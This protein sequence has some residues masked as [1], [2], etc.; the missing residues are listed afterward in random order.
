MIVSEYEPIDLNLR[1]SRLDMKTPFI[2]TITSVERYINMFSYFK[3]VQV[4]SNQVAANTEL[5][6]IDMFDHV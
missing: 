3:I 6:D 5:T 4:F 1:F 2:Y